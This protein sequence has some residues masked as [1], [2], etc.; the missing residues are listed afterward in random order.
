VYDS[1]NF[2]CKP[3]IRPEAEDHVGRFIKVIEV[4]RSLLVDDAWREGPPVFTELSLPRLHDPCFVEILDSRELNGY[5]TLSARIPS[6]LGT[7]QLHGFVPK[8]VAAVI[9]GSSKNVQ[10]ERRT[11]A[12]NPVAHPDPVGPARSQ[13]T[14]FHIGWV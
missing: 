11:H 13:A 4:P 6:V 9:A 14:I 7:S 3:L 5:P 10:Q 8:A 2:T 1:W 12:D